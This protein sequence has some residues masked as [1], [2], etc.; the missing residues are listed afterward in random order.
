MGGEGQ[1]QTQATIFS[2]YA[3]QNLNLQTAINLPRWLLGRTW[4]EE[5][6]SLKVEG[7]FTKGTF[8]KLKSLG[9]VIE[10]VGDFE[11]IMGH[12]GAIVND[13]NGS[14]EGAYDLRSDGSAIGE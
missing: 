14:I 5:T 11:E 1:P 3:I 7:R 9:H 6:T 8:D 2:R 4:G 13:P 12:A 10:K